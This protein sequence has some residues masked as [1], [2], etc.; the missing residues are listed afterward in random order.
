[1]QRR[2]LACQ[3]VNGVGARRVVE[4]RLAL[5][6]RMTETRN[7]LSELRLAKVSE[8]SLTSSVVGLWMIPMSERPPRSI[9]V[10]WNPMSLDTSS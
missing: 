2:V 5:P 7:A 10:H 1:M 8:S 6:P 9:K 4:L 3:M